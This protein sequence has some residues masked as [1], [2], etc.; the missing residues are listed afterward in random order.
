MGQVFDIKVDL[1]HP[2]LPQADWVDCYSVD[3]PSQFSTAREA[4]NA[5]VAHFPKWTYPALALRQILVSPFGLKGSK[6][7]KSEIGKVGIF[8]I[9][10]ESESQLIAG[11][12]D[13][14]LDFR[15]VIDLI[16][17]NDGQTVSMTTLINRHN[18]LGRGYLRL[19]LPFHRAIIRSALSGL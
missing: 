18:V 4:G 7:G 8:P 17:K 9:L 12:D 13:K 1:P 3:V 11:L 16:D 10:S 19:V 5:I 14:H 2:G 6:D 15:I